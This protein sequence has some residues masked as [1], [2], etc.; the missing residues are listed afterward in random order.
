MRAKRIAILIEMAVGY[1]EAILR[2]LW[3]YLQTRSDWVCQGMDPQLEEIALLHQWKPDGI[4]AGIHVLEVGESLKKL[5][6]P[7]VD[8]FNWFEFTDIAK[9]SV[10]DEAVGRMA[11][12]HLL[13]RGFQTFGVVGRTSTL[14][15]REREAGFAAAIRGAGCTYSAPGEVTPPISWSAAFR[16]G[17]DKTLLQ[18]LRKLPRP[19]GIFAISDSWGVQVIETCR[20]AGIRV[21]DEI[22]VLGVDND[23]LLCEIANPQMS[24]VASA[25]E[26]VG[27]RAGEIMA[28]M[29]SKKGPHVAATRVRPLHVI[30]RQS[31][32]ILALRD[33]DVL[34]AL[35]FIR[36]NMHKSVSVT[37][38]LRVVPLRRRTLER[39]FQAFVGRT[40]LEEI[41]LA[42]I[43]RAKGLLLST[44]LKLSAVAKRSGFGGAQ[45][46]CRVFHRLTGQ[47]PAAFRRNKALAS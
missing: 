37:E 40:I 1:R 22:A 23:K 9:V 35:R 15:S 38:V 39:R 44:D 45:Q 27:Y 4:I 18:W 20:Q 10:D 19:A 24:S 30:E 3:Q 21:P 7:V 25:P 12:D 11:A 26:R 43:A 2:G 13:S 8:V 32:D 42:R 36:T 17:A 46:L 6:K 29:L 28:K 41:R 31:T 5:G 14:C 33:A 47:T 34:A 16:L